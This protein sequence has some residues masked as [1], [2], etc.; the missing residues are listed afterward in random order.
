MESEQQMSQDE[1]NQD[2]LTQDELTQ[3]ELNQIE[4]NQYMQARL[5][6]YL[7]SDFDDSYEEE[8][9]EDP[10]PCWN[11]P[12]WKGNSKC[13]DDC[14]NTCNETECFNGQEAVVNK[15]KCQYCVTRIDQFNERRGCADCD[16][17]W[18]MPDLMFPLSDEDEEDEET[19]ASASASAGADACTGEMERD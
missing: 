18:D 2:E 4:L 7:N 11:I 15:D 13:F 8:D 14:I 5:E 17:Y 1:L 10:N 6:H 19:D 9:D 16:E 12:N 3:D